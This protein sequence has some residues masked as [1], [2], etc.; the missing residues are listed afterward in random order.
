MRVR[1][2]CRSVVAP[3][4][5]LAG[6]MVTR[7][8]DGAA[9]AAAVTRWAANADVG[10]LLVDDVLYRALPRDLLSRLD[11]QGLPLVAPVPAP[12]WDERSEAEAYILEILRRAVGYRV[13]PR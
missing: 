8:D 4:F 3:G 13:R 9:V 7:V 2:L 1:V 5:E 11:R 10:A 6:M 12:R